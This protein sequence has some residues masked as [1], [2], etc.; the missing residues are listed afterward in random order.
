MRRLHCAIAAFCLLP[1]AV[2]IYGQALAID[3]GSVSNA[4]SYISTDYPNGGVT[5]GGMFIVKALG[6]AVRLGACGTKLASQFPLST[7]MNG[8]SMS[9]NIGGA[10]FDI[11]MIYVVACAGVDQLAGIVPSNVP[12]GNG[13]LTVTYNGRSGTSPIT[14]VDREPG[15]FTINQ[16]GS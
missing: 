16:G 4:A 9:I 3:V 14:V 12:V 13:T 1:A 5:H 6:T 2:R 10:S 15:F 7:N 8:T 11:P